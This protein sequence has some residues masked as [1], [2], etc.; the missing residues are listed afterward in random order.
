MPEKS[1]LK[2]DTLESKETDDLKIFKVSRKRRR[3]KELGKEGSFVVLNSAP[4]VN[5]I[6]LTENNKVIMIEQYR[7][8]IDDL[9]LEIP[10]GLVEDGE[11]PK[12][13]GER[14]CTEET[15][16]AGTGNAILLGVNQPNPAF[17]D[18]L[19]Y[20]FIWFDCKKL[21]EQKLDRHEDIRV[22]EVP[23]SE[24]KNMIMEGAIKHSLVLNA[25][26]YFFL[27]YDI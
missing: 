4:W 2:W 14:E 18:N 27:R 20:S 17:L 1:V 15:G 23:L 5:I 19:C 24:I 16:Y 13:A 9:T 26:F 22:M 10:G 8:G 11:E 7:Q 6:P 3:N 12:A 25:F 21:Y